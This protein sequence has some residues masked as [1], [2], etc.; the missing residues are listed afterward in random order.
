MAGLSSRQRIY[1]TVILYI[2]IFV[3]EK[4]ISPSL[5][6][7]I[8]LYISLPARCEAGEGLAVRLSAH[9]LDHRG[10]GENVG[11]PFI[12]QD[13]AFGGGVVREER[14]G[15]EG[16]GSSRGGRGFDVR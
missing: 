15:A 5:R 8:I 2:L 9:G 1:Y 10:Q 11:R 13:S 12:D 3:S 16:G 14:A 6:I 7:D 4:T